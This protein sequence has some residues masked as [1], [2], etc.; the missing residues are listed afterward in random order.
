MTSCVVLGGALLA[1]ALD[2]TL[3]DPSNRWHPVAWMGALIRALSPA[4]RPGRHPERSDWV[5]APTEAERQV[6]KRAHLAS[7]VV[8][9]FLRGTAITLGGALLFSLPLW[10]ALRWLSGWGWPAAL[11]VSVVGL[12]MTIGYRGLARA[13]REVQRAL[14]AGD[15][16]EAR[17]LLS[18][19]LVSRDTSRLGA[20]LVAAATIE[21]VAENLTDGL[22][23][24]LFYYLLGGTPGAWAYRFV[25]TC[26]SLLGYHD[27]IHE[28]LGKFPARL[29]DVL[30]WLPARLTGLAL[31]MGAALAGE[32]GRGALRTML[33]QHG[34]TASPNAGWT[35]S[36]MAGALGV[37]LEKVGHYRLEGGAEVPG[38][39]GIDRALRVA[40][41]T[42]LVTLGSLAAAALLLLVWQWYGGR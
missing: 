16:P 9:P 41:A 13:A 42:L 6:L 38:A 11:L 18:W 25:N 27:P 17:R 1:M 5:P 7:S 3:G 30:N 14:E 24:P 21:S 26:D 31:A 37:T 32:D 8:A 22:T 12:K 15:L 35:M 20:D 40:R 33:A 36:A 34:R 10:L 28:Y 4:Q 2:L 23:A 29:D 19:H 39:E